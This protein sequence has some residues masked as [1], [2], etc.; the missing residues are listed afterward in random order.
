MSAPAEIQVDQLPRHCFGLIQRIDAPG[1]DAERLM[2]MGICAGRTVEMI[3]SGDP[4]IIKVFA[5]RIGLSA[6]LAEHVFVTPLQTRPP[7]AGG[8]EP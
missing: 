3:K 4:L 7:P 8:T 1:D 5:S 6:R 2:A